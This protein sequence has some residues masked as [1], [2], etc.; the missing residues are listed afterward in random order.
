MKLGCSETLRWHFSPDNWNWRRQSL[1]DFQRWAQRDE[2]GHPWNDPLNDAPSSGSASR[3]RS[4]LSAARSV[5]DRVLVVPTGHP[6][7]DRWIVLHIPAGEQ[8]VEHVDIIHVVSRHADHD[9]AIRLTDS[10]SVRHE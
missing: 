4:R 6:L 8:L 5:C 3:P 1:D 9:V 7:H 2:T 10:D